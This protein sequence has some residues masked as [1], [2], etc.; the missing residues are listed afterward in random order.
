MMRALSILSCVGLLAC[1]GPQRPIRATSAIGGSLR[2][3]EHARDETWRELAAADPRFARRA[4]L[5]PSQAEVAKAMQA[6]LVAEENA[7]LLGGGPDPFTRAP[8]DRALGLSKNRLEPLMGGAPSLDARLELAG[9]IAVLREEQARFDREAS[10]PRAGTRLIRALAATEPPQ[11]IVDASGSAT[12]EEMRRTDATL[13]RRLGE[14]EDS[15][16]ESDSLDGDA[17]EDALD[18]LEPLLGPSYV[19][20]EKALTSLRLACNQKL[21]TPH[22]ARPLPPMAARVPA[23]AKAQWIALRDR[24]KKEL[25]AYQTPAESVRASEREAEA[26]QLLFEATTCG[27]PAWPSSLRPSPERVFACGALQHART[28]ALLLP[29]IVHDLL[30]LGIWALEL[31]EN[32][33]GYRRVLSH[34]AMAGRVS[35]D[36][37][38]KIA[39]RAAA[40]PELALRAGLLGQELAGIAPAQRPAWILAYFERGSFLPAEVSPR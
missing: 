35:P 8:R 17:I 5:Q 3:I 16:D 25:L 30:T 1:A 36:V 31:A 9:L 4:H 6:S 20:A 37:G 40:E 2:D 13:S 24:M 14:I 21:A 15:L 19:D 7:A 10:L 33:D 32:R 26:T 38:S 22:G 29:L 18:E 34:Y 39:R 23:D 11:S 28:D 12:P 27:A